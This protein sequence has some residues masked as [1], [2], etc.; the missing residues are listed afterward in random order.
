MLKLG[1][2]ITPPIQPQLQQN[3]LLGQ[4]NSGVYPS[5][6][7]NPNMKILSYIGGANN[8]GDMAQPGLQGY[9]L[10]GQSSLFEGI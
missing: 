3:N 8:S 4:Q 6:I 5:G 7:S 10:Q 9:S 2:G 1:N